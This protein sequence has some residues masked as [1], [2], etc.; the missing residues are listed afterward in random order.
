M[1]PLLKHLKDTLCYDC[2]LGMFFTGPISE[3]FVRKIICIK[4]I[5]LCICRFKYKLK[6]F[7]KNEETVSTLSQKNENP[8]GKAVLDVKYGFFQPP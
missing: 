5:D 7:R 3:T 4:L 6:K 8:F 2:N 1:F